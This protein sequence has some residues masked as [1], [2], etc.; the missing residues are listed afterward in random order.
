MPNPRGR[1]FLVLISVLVGLLVVP[2]VALAGPAKGKGGG[3]KTPPATL[4]VSPDPV[5]AGGANYT[6]TGDGFN[7]GQIVYINESR[8]YCCSAYNILADDNGHIEFTRP[9][10][11]AGTYTITA[12]QKK[13]RR[14]VT[15]AEVSFE[16][17]SG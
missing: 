9:S 7:P 8:P 5:A 13:K 11:F 1:T 10:G 14:F 15:M 3:G 4:I 6:V 17:V 16:V 12:L 2:S